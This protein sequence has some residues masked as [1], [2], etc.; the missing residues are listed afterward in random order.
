MKMNKN[1]NKENQL[2]LD[3]KELREIKQELLRFNER[4]DYLE[5]CILKTETIL[6]ER[7]K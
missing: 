7:K 2:L 3:L 6:K 5:S 1:K 4:I